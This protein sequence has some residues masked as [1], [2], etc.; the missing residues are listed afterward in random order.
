M[1]EVLPDSTDTNICG[2]QQ[3]RIEMCTPTCDKMDIGHENQVV[4][5]DVSLPSVDIISADAETLNDGFQE[6]SY[7]FDSVGFSSC[8]YRTSSS[9]EAIGSCS[10]KRSSENIIVSC[11][12]CTEKEVDSTFH[13]SMNVIQDVSIHD[14]DDTEF[15]DFAISDYCKT[16]E[17]NPLT[18]NNCDTLPT[19]ELSVLSDQSDDNSDSSKMKNEYLNKVITCHQSLQDSLA[20]SDFGDF[21]DFETDKLHVNDNVSNNLNVSFD[22]HCEDDNFD[23]ENEFR[24]KIDQAICD[25]DEFGDFTSSTNFASKHKTN[26]Q[27]P[28]HA[29]EKPSHNVA[30]FNMKFFNSSTTASISE[31]CYKV[32]KQIFTFFTKMF[33]WWLMLVYV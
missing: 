1:T 24:N 7:I 20:D 26:D 32:K 14:H 5:S 6:E 28:V 29:S 16:P 13:E 30:E 8:T 25:D 19:C 23:V 21:T 4:S 11:R 10:C 3:E 31:H 18:V 22:Y 15:G 2:A 9:N 27:V 12:N 33:S 17:N